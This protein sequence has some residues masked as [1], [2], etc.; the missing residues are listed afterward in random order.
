MHN[1]QRTAANS[2]EWLSRIY[3]NDTAIQWNPKFM[4]VFERFSGFSSA[5]AHVDQHASILITYGDS[6]RDDHGEKPLKTLLHFLQ[7]YVGSAISTVHIL[8]CYPASSDDG[9]SV[10]DPFQV[11]SE[12]GTWEDIHHLA[13]TYNLMLDFVANHLSR[14]HVWIEECLK[15]NPEFSDFIIFM[16]GSEDLHTVFRPRL[17]PL[18]TSIQTDS[19][20]K[21]VWTTFSADQIDLNY[22]NP[23]V[24]L[25]MIE[26]L[27]T[28]VQHHASI[29]RLDAIAY[30]WKELGTSCI[31]HPKTHLII[32]YFRWILDAMASGTL[33]ITETN[34]PH[35]DNISYFG[36]G[37]NEAS[38]VYNFPLPPL[39]LHTFLTQNASTLSQWIKTLALPSTQVA[40][41]NF[42]SSH[43]GIGLVPVR[44]ILESEEIESLAKHVIAQGGFISKRT[45]RNGSSSPYELN[46]NYFSAFHGISENETQDTHRD[47]CI[48]ATAIMICMQG[49]CGVYIHSLLGSEN[50][51]DA[52]D[53][54]MHP[55]TI[56]REKLDYQKLCTE[57]E[58]TQS[59]RSGIF[60]RYVTLLS[61]RKHERA[62][63]TTVAQ[64]V[65]DAGNTGVLALLRG[66]GDDDAY[67]LCLINVTARTLMLPQKNLEQQ[68]HEI[69]QDDRPSLWSNLLVPNKEPPSSFP[70]PILSPYQVILLKRQA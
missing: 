31:H 25:H 61:I 18:L 60:F 36:N 68:I 26:V 56:N 5:S 37:F 49:I 15:G 34:V 50:W 44:G 19:G 24:L 62:L 7:H 33:I 14:S 4:Q 46:I 2:L 52:P 67:I 43:D 70:E 6:I 65:L 47:R 48:A 10:V 28:Y 20:N 63:Q 32:Q 38:L 22:Q 1:E 11:D 59:K 13:Q 64:H 45:N 41:F 58:D 39:V 51:T 42:L 23:K 55:R 40:F 53:L 57:L 16:D 66:P 21:L 29:V 9:F 30:I 3:G 17:H 54:S 27:L 69:I 8:P 35:K 12:L